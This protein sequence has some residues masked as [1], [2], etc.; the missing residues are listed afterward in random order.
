MTVPSRARRLFAGWSANFFQM[1]LGVTQQIALVPVFLHF[2]SSEAFGR[3]ARDLCRRQSCSDRRLRPAVSCDQPVSRASNRA[4]IAIGG[5]RTFTQRCCGSIRGLLALSSSCCWSARSF[6]RLPRCWDFRPIPDFDAAF[7]VMTAGMLLALPSNL[8]SGLYRARGLYGRAVRL[9]NW[10][11][12]AAQL[13]STGCDRRDRKPAGR[14]H[15]VCG[16]ATAHRG[17]FSGDRCSPAVSVLARR[18]RETFVALDCRPVSQRRSVCGCGCHRAGTAQSAGAA[19]QRFCDRPRRRGAMGPYPRRRGTA[20]VALHSDDASSGS[21]ARPRLCRRPEGPVAQPL[22]ARVGV[23]D[24]AGERCGLRAFAVLA[25]F[26][27]ALDPWRD[28]LRS[29]RSRS[30]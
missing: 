11:M 21:R 16:N 29:R 4:W 7:V 5:P 9:Q 28:S 17:L 22:C 18:A 2:W 12:L 10:G 13:G 23:R 30:P 27:R 19:G 24:V 3:V 14:H 25:G 26:F 8:V 6:F 1:I 15:R 20:A